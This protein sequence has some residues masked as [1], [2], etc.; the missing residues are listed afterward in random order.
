MADDSVEIQVWWKAGGGMMYNTYG[1]PHDHEMHPY[2]QILNM[3]KDPA[4]Y[5]IEHP[6]AEEFREVTRADLIKEVVHLRK[7]LE[8]VAAAGF[9]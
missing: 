8:A 1:L 7:E 5:G 9:Y 6:L 2:N 4:A 3:G